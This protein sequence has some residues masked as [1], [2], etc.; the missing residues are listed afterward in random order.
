MAMES[1]LW[2][3]VFVTVYTE[4]YETDE[5]LPA[6]RETTIEQDCE[7]CSSAEDGD[8]FGISSLLHGLLGGFFAEDPQKKLQDDDTISVST[9]ESSHQEVADTDSDAP[10]AASC[11]GS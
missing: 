11:S 4:V 9:A 10:P 2:S 7:K 6:E 8:G 1:L 5:R 3:D